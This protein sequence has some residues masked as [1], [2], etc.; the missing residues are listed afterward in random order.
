MINFTIISRLSKLTLFTALAVILCTGCATTKT[1]AVKQGNVIVNEI[2]NVKLHSFM[3]VSVTPVIIESDKLIIIDFPGDSKENAELFKKYVDGLNKPI[4]RYFISHIHSA[5]WQ[6]VEKLFTG[7]TF[8]SVDADAIKA[9]K[10]GAGLSIMPI[11]DGSKM[12]VNGIQ[13][14]FDVDREIE[15][16]M[17]KLPK[18]KA[19]YVDHLGYIDLHVLIAPLEPRLVHLRKLAREGYTWYMPG[20]GAPMQNPDFLNQ[21]EAYYKDV[22]EIVKKYRTIPEVRTA[23]LEKYPNYA[24]PARLD[25][26]LPGLTQW[27]W[28]N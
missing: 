7:M 28:K 12:T 16:W 20:H 24:S 2:S 17:I 25:R 27:Y 8:H 3:S 1:G 18:L 15:A 14:V 11:T 9:T 26:M 4:E 5:H 6:G 13:L 22:L 23:I 21:V 10:E 19:V